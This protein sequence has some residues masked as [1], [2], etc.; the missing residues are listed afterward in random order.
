[1]STD[2]SALPNIGAVLAEELEKAGIR[3][4]E[5]LRDIGSVQAA[6]RI[7]SGD[8]EAC[9]NLLFALEGAIR[10]VRWHSMPKAER[11][12]LKAEFDRATQR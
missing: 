10:G 9:Y 12:E 8:K 3:S 4:P 6:A 7:A 11:A 1:M 2:L 5:Q